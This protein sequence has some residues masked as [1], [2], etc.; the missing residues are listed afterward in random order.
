MRR[1]A[2]RAAIAAL[3]DPERP[4]AD[5][6]TNTRPEAFPDTQNPRSKALKAPR[7]PQ[8]QQ[9]AQDQRQVEPGHMNQQT[10]QNVLVFPEMRPPPGTLM[11]LEHLVAVV[12]LVRHDLAE[13]SLVNRIPGFGRHHVDNVLT[14][15]FQRLFDA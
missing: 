2:D 5:T 12:T 7:R 14:G 10:F 6:P 11:L 1:G 15:R 8:A 3:G 9:L 13:G 4:R